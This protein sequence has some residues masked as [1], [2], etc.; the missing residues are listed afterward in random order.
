MAATRGPVTVKAV[1]VVAQT[2]TAE[3]PC[4]GSVMDMR[5]GAYMITSDSSDL[6]CDRCGNVVKLGK[7]A[8]LFC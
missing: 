5:T 2:A 7:T 4:G 3:C 1:S 6:K 8:R